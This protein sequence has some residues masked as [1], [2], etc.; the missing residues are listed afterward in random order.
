MLICHVA[1]LAGA[2]LNM[3]IAGN[4]NFWKGMEAFHSAANSFVDAGMYV[5]Y[6]VKPD[7][8]LTVQPFVAP[9]T[10]VETFN[11]ILQ[12]LLDKLSSL[13]VTYKLDKAQAFPTFNDLYSS[14]F[15]LSSDVGGNAIMGGRLFSRDD[16]AKNDAA[17][18][19][20]M[21]TIVEAGHTFGG[22]MVNPGRA[23]PDPTTSI[24]AVHP[25]WRNAADS[26]LW[27]YNAPECLNEDGRKQ[28][29]NN[30]THVLGD[31]LRKA[32]PSSAVYVN[33]VSATISP[34]LF[35]FQSHRY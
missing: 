18:V 32:S 4:P 23:V 3:T 2:T 9:N 31:A 29:F 27:L 1:E 22:H 26:S 11:K 25:V 34:V 28:V 12:P 16:V 17:I 19:A 7:T 5:W 21:R 6:T 15:S 24:S 35:V 10:T 14:L 20:A 33:E 8:G 30:V 13:N